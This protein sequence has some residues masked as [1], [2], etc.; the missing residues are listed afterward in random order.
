MK[1]GKNMGGM[2]RVIRAVI[3][4][5]LVLLAIFADMSMV[6]VVVLVII[7]AVLLVTATAGI[8]PAYLPLKFSTRGKGAGE[9]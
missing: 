1:I 9:A 7:A 4:V 6:A 8:C 5:V 3:G 2:D